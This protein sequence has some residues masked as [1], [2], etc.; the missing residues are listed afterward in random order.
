[1]TISS[2]LLSTDQQQNVTTT[3][4]RKTSMTP[5]T[6]TTT[7]TIRKSDVHKSPTKSGLV[8]TDGG[9]LASQFGISSPLDRMAL[10]ANGNLQRL[11]SSYYDAPVNV[12]VDQCTLVDDANSQSSSSTSTLSMATWDRVVHLVVHGQTFCTARSQ[13]TV[14]NP[15]C[16]DLVQSGEVGLGQLFRYLDKL[17]TFTL[18]DA[19]LKEEDGALWRL[20]DLSCKELSCR[21]HEDFVPHAWNIPPP[22][23]KY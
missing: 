7:T 19:G 18:L 6:T 9:T 3:A 2:S 16:L 17:P 13:I 21:I 11:F 15:K 23:K 5:P 8:T 20:Y 1:M 4:T 22:N 10:T 12:L 14:R